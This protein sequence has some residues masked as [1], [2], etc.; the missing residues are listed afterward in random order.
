MPELPA[1]PHLDERAEFSGFPF[2]ILFV[3]FRNRAVMCRSPRVS[4]PPDVPFFLS[5]LRRC[6]LRLLISQV[7]SVAI[8][9][10]LASA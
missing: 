10:A 2:G 9:G 1:A 6:P 5:R 7:G 3:P 8:L 4:F